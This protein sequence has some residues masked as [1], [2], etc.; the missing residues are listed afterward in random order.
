[1]TAALNIKEI[2]LKSFIAELQYV[3]VTCRETDRIKDA[4]EQQGCVSFFFL[5]LKGKV[6]QIRMEVAFV[7]RTLKRQNWSP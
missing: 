6:T 5:K 3:T 1:M 2:W 4:T 7:V